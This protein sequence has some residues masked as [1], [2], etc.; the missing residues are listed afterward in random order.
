VFLPLM[1][2]YLIG[3]TLSNRA[4]LAAVQPLYRTSDDRFT[5]AT[6]FTTFS[7]NSE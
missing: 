4:G 3:S 5:D 6:R 2:G 1:T 7:N